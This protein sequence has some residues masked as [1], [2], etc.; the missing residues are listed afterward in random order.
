MGE[1][2]QSSQTDRLKNATL[3]TLKME[4]EVMSQAGKSKKT[5][6]QDHSPAQYL[7]FRTFNFQ[8]CQIINLWVL[9]N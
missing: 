8:S 4:E 1:Q 3:L 2:K 6:S 5:D 7:D 9:S